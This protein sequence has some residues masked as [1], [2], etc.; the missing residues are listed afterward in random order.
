MVRRRGKKHES[1]M[2]TLVKAHERATF[3]GWPRIQTL[4]EFGKQIRVIDRA[5]SVLGPCGW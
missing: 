2:V 3:A 4:A 1:E 5:R